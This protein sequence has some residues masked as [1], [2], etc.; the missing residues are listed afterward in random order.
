MKEGD[1]VFIKMQQADGRD[2][3]RPAILLRKLPP[4]GDWLICGISS[5]LDQQESDFDELI[6]IRDS[7][8]AN[9]GL[10]SHSLI[11]LGFL[12]VAER[13]KILGR[14]GSISA[15]RHARLL[16]KLSDYLAPKSA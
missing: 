3:L 11:R 8:Y 15:K 9:S 14:I 13:S 12:F 1:T 16:K 6:S 7:D 10:R 4:Y 5:Q 2:K